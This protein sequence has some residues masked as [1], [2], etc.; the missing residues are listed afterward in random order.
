[1]TMTREEALTIVT[2][3][4]REHSRECREPK[5]CQDCELEAEAIAALSAQAD[6]KQA[7]PCPWVRQSSEGTAYCELAESGAKQAETLSPWLPIESAP[8]DGTVVMLGYLPNWRM[9]RLVYEGRW[10]AEQQCWTSVNGFQLH[11]DATHWMPLPAPPALH[12]LGAK[13]EVSDG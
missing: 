6:T 1:M 10:C 2:S 12:Q 7:E 13:V 9:D 3:I 11:T 4:V 8:R 5:P